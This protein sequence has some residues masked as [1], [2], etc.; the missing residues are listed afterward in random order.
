MYHSIS[1]DPESGMHPY[2]RV[3]TTPARF[4][5]QMQWLKDNGYQGVTLRQGLDSQKQKAESRKHFQRAESQLSAQIG[6]VT[7]PRHLYKKSQIAN[8]KSQISTA[9]LTFDD[10]FRDFYTTAWPIL[11][12]FGFTATMYLPTAFIGDTPRPLAPRSQGSEVRG[13]RPEVRGQ[14]P[15]LS[16]F[17]LSAFSFQILSWSEI[18]EIH[19]AGIEFG[20]HTANHPKLTELSWPEIESELRDSKSEIENH[21]GIP[22]A[23]FAYP[24]A[25]PPQANGDFVNR[26]KDLLARCGY[27]TNVTTQIGRHRP[28][29][30]ALQIKRLPV[31]QDDDPPLFA[32]K[33]AGAYDWLGRVQ[34]LSKTLRSRAKAKG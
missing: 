27:Q 25:F 8:R 26:F 34:S 19:R 22:C 4:R 2:Y 18:G 28:A 23:A 21:L 29:D 17:Q 14:R 31:N 13:Q 32:A 15:G 33:V 5:E 10:G 12:E 6:N 11:R 3:C 24:Y 1:D 7:T 16:R 9:V 30:D 20:S